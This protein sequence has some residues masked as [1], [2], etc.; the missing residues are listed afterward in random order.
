[1]YS[2]SRRGNQKRQGRAGRGAIQRHEQR[3]ERQGRA[4][5]PGKEE[6]DP[7]PEGSP[8]P[9]GEVEGEP[10][11]GEVG[12][13]GGAIF[14]TGRTPREIGGRAKGETRREDMGGEAQVGTG[15]GRD[16]RAAPGGCGRITPEPGR[17][18]AEDGASG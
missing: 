15:A 10:V 7:G 18:V 2:R 6:P 16:Y 4:S 5:L 8:L 17:V 3:E 9:G 13:R 1:M 12:D 14:W 11:G